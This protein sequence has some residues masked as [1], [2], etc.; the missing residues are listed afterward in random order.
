MNAYRHTLYANK[1][2]VNA[3]P[4]ANS[5]QVSEC[6]SFSLPFDAAE[7]SPA[8][9]SPSPPSGCGTAAGWPTSL[10]LS[11]YTCSSSKVPPKRA[12]K[13]GREKGGRWEREGRERGGRGEG[14]GRERGGRGEG[15]EEV[16]VA[17]KH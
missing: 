8:V 3:C 9:S 7:R 11:L 1:Y 6:Q 4:S 5:K 10:P 15:E 13:E 17:N 2:Y 14:E 16:P 12:K